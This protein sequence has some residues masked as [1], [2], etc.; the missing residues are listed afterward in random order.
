[1]ADTIHQIQA[2]KAPPTDP[3]AFTD[4][5]I[6]QMLALAFPADVVQTF[7]AMWTGTIKYTAVRSGVMPTDQVDPATLSDF[8]NIQ[9]AYDPSNQAQQLTFQGVLLDLQK[10]KIEHANSS[11]VLSRLLTDVQ[12]Q[13][14]TFFQKYFQVATIGQKTIGFLPPADF[15]L[16]FLD[17]PQKEGQKRTELAQTLLPYL[18]QKLIHQAVVEATVANLSADASLVETLITNADLLSDP[19]QPSKTLLDAF[20]SV[21]EQGLS[22]TYYASNDGS[23][24]PLV[25]GTASTADT[26]NTQ[27]PKPSGT[28]SA[29]FEGYVQVPA[30]GIYRFFVELG[31][32]NAQA[33]LQFDFPP[34]PFI[35]A[36]ASTDQA[37][38]SSFVALKAVIPY[39]VTADFSNLGG[40]NASLLV[41]GET[42]PRGSFSQLTLYPQAAV[43][44]FTHA[45]VLLSKTH[46]LMQGLGLN[47]REVTYLI[48]HS[49]DFE[50]LS[51]S[52]LPTQPSE[53]SVAA[54]AK[55]VALFG[56]F[57]RLTTYASL[58]QG[59]AGGS[60]GLI[61]VFEQARQTFLANTTPDDAVQAV[62][63]KLY[64]IVANLTRRDK[65]VVQAIAEQ[66]GLKPQPSQTVG[67]NLLVT[68]PDFTQE[69][70]F[71]RLWDALQLVQ[72]IGISAADLADATTIIDGSKTTE[73]RATIAGKLKNA[74]K[75]H[76]TPDAWRPIAQSIFDQLRQ[77]KRDALSAYLVHHL[78]LENREQ[79]FEYFLVDPGMEPVVKTSRLRLALSSV[80]TFIQRCLL[81][82]EPKVDPSAIPANQWEWMKRYRVWQANRE[83]FLWPENWMEPEWRLDKT[84]LFLALESAL[85][86]GDVTNDLVEDAFYTYL[87]DLEVRARL[88]IVTMYL[89]EVLNDPK[90]DVL[91]VIGRNHGK[92]QKYFYRRFSFGIWNAWE[93][94]KVDIEGDHLALVKW[95]DRLHL[96][97]VTFSPTNAAPEIVSKTPG[98]KP[99]TLV[100][101]TFGDLTENVPKKQ[102][103]LQLNW[104]EY[105]QGKWSDRKASD[106]N[107][108]KPIDV[109]KDF[110][111][112]SAYIH[113]TKETDDS[114]NEGAV[115]IILDAPL[116][117]AFR[118]VGK[119]SEPDASDAK[120]VWEYYH[121]TSTKQWVDATKVA[122]S[123]PL[124]VHFTDKDTTHIN[125]H[126]GQLIN[127]KEV[128]APILQKGYDFALLLCDTPEILPS[129]SDFPV[130]FAAQA[131]ALG[132][133]FF[134]QDRDDDI[135]LFVQPSLSDKSLTDWNG[136]VIPVPPE[137]CLGSDN[138]W[139]A[140]TVKDQVP[141]FGTVNPG[142]PSA[143]Y[144]MQSRVDW[145]TQPNTAISL[146][147]TLIGLSGGLSLQ[148]ELVTGVASTGSFAAVRNAQ[149]NG[150]QTLSSGTILNAV[151]P[152]GLTL[153]GLQASSIER[154]SVF[155]SN[156]VQPTLNQ[157][158]GGIA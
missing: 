65:M 73:A 158:E 129:R 74:V 127:T 99:P 81:N 133:P 66:L 23:G 44:R 38:A 141:N 131:R 8:S 94:V 120:P 91:H 27:M 108:A 153:A 115:K 90:S 13:A 89:E 107:R 78:R 137:C 33:R 147:T 121:Y 45:L 49:A 20:A 26:A 134:Y 51:F 154:S 97:W 149:P 67:N 11:T 112:L 82:L 64:Q 41:Q 135:T 10:S 31:K 30:D 96:F 143:K 47:E 17:D 55:A 156:S 86:Q 110:D 63:D 24:Q 2:E 25:M 54:K 85:L 88:D 34:N 116:G 114:G 83:I 79:L 35:L 21:G 68:V 75:A 42:M 77:E 43:D 16:L 32:Q 58:K 18:Q 119:N 70:G 12:D 84:D 146:G 61:D 125:M 37:E 71:Q 28:G 101:M 132:R 93:P 57:L 130:D 22:V 40:G 102:V 92:P 106:L 100:Q 122:D 53:D 144:Q 50:N 140:V 29:H 151:G 155:A 52:A 136:W 145:A 36:V 60:D 39:H 6:K 14:K 80:Q 48:G 105:F 117:A 142:D 124:Q 118:L 123:G 87:K 126:N 19:I 1:M 5:V 72:T 152:A 69:K 157:A 62:I 150:T 111:P 139:E 46:Q 113:V 9:L 3:Q 109:G 104:S 15:D 7:L 76:Y 56:Q 95:R 103:K 148:H 98:A 4:Q 138:W 128:S 59:P